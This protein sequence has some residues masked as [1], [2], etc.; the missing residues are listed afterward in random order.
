MNYLQLVNGVLRRM[1][2]NEV[3]TVNSDPYSKMVG[4]FVNDAKK[5][6]ETSY[7]WGSL[8]TTYT[9]ETTAGTFS[10]ALTGA[11]Q[12]IQMLRFWNDTSNTE[13]RY[14]TQ[15]WFDRVYLTIPIQEG[16]PDRFTFNGVDSNGDTVIDVYPM[17]DAVYTL[18]FNCVARQPDL[19]NNTDEI[20]VPHMPV[21]HL[22]VALAARERGETGGTTTQEYF[23]IAERYLSDAVALESSKHPEEM[24]WS[25]V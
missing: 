21:L 12:D 8:R 13:M 15:S 2:E 1:R 22:A 6:V 20:I 17:P 24:I 5:I 10:Y 16:S 3:S 4:D 11:G 23:A 9:I 7:G 19:V 25:Y 18:R 14:E